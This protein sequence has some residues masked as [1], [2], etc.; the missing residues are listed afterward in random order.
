MILTEAKKR[1]QREFDDALARTGLTVDE[2][3][4]YLRR[5][6]GDEA[7]DLPSAR[8]T[9]PPPAPR[10][11]S[12]CTWPQ[13]MGRPVAAAMMKHRRR[14][15]R[16]HHRQGGGGGGR[17]G[18]LAGLPAPQH[19]PGREGRSSSSSAWRPRPA[20]RA[21]Q[22][23]IFFTGSGAGFLAPLVGGQAHPG[24]RRGRGV[25]RAAASGRA[26]RVRDRRRGHEDDLLHRHRHRDDPSRSTCSRRAAA[27][28]GTF[29]EKT[30]RKLQVPSEQ[31]AEHAL[32]RA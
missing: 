29:I 15:R 16:L 7:G 20:S 8:T 6:P 21:G 14:R 5:A 10:P 24:G 28:P 17:H 4:A 9:A 19:P 27:A 26:L 22:D 30:A 31:L 12:S 23:R 1:A 25:R 3:R 32:R 18:H 2:V 11:T 13:K